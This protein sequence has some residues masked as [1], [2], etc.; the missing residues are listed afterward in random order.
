MV[1]LIRMVGEY[2]KLWGPLMAGYA[3]AAVPIIILFAT[4]IF[5][6]WLSLRRAV[7]NDERIAL[8]REL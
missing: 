8:L 2:I 5:F 3:M 1:Q 6:S 7:I 4:V